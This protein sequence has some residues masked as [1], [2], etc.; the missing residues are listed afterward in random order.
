MTSPFKGWTLP[1]IRKLAPSLVAKE[2]VKVQPMSAPVYDIFSAFQVFSKHPTNSD[3][4]TFR[5]TPSMGKDEE[6]QLAI[7]KICFRDGQN[8]YT[9]IC[10]IVVDLSGMSEEL[11]K[12]FISVGLAELH[13]QIDMLSIAEDFNKELAGKL[14]E[15]QKYKIQCKNR[16]NQEETSQPKFLTSEENC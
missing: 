12:E 8:Y 13:E 16:Q 11:G 3:G 15:E 14:L 1:E 5:I 2:I 4:V 10:S 7:F 6:K 9:E